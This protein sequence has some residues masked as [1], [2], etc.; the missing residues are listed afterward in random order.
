METGNK[1]ERKGAMMY[2]NWMEDI[3]NMPKSHQ[4]EAF[5]IFYDL[6]FGEDNVTPD[7]LPIYLR[8]FYT[9]LKVAEQKA[10]KEL[11]R[12]ASNNTDFQETNLQ[13]SDN[14]PR[15]KVKDKVKDKVKVNTAIETYC[16]CMD[17]IEKEKVKKEKES[18]VEVVAETAETEGEETTT[19]NN[20]EQLE[21]EQEVVAETAETEAHNNETKKDI[22]M[23]RKDYWESVDRYCTALQQGKADISHLEQYKR[24]LGK[25]Y[26]GQQLQMMTLQL[27]Q[28]VNTSLPKPAYTNNTHTITD[29]KQQREQFWKD[30][31]GFM[32]LLKGGTPKA[33]ETLAT[34]I[35]RVPAIYSG[36]YIDK[37]LTTI[38]KEFGETGYYNS[39]VKWVDKELEA[40]LQKH[41]TES[42]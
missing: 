26:E 3:F 39:S 28:R 9:H 36:D 7:E 24:L 16:E 34:F 23:E 18:E 40:R 27:E 22:E 30:W 19:N 1:Y 6:Y 5:H 2:K 33:W 4:L 25:L 8:V 35:E 14:Y 38:K 42:E 13:L 41:S 20:N 31:N 37:T 29:Y 15:T 11:K 17:T 21:K 32:T 10:R 12:K